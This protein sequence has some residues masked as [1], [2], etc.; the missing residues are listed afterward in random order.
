[1]EGPARRCTGA[2]GGTR[3]VYRVADRLQRGERIRHLGAALLTG[4]GLTHRVQRLAEVI[5]AALEVIPA[6]AGPLGERALP[7]RC[8]HGAVERRALRVGVGGPQAPTSSRGAA[9]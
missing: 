7:F 6:G 4:R 5:R 8:A 2:A 9:G 3:G 1:M